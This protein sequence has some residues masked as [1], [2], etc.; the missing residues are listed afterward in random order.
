MKH[1]KLLA[2]SAILILG[3]N[4]AM[5]ADNSGQITSFDRRV[6]VANG[7][8]QQGTVKIDRNK[9]Q[10][11]VTWCSPTLL[12]M[13]VYDGVSSSYPTHYQKLDGGD[14]PLQVS[15]TVYTPSLPF[16]YFGKNYGTPTYVTSICS[17]ASIHTTL[18]SS[19][20]HS[21]KL[22]NDLGQA[23][24]ISGKKLAVV[25]VN[26][27]QGKAGYYESGSFNGPAYGLVGGVALL[28]A[29]VSSTVTAQCESNGFS[30]NIK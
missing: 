4:V 15:V 27:N 16:T 11:V 21:V 14:H 1:L 26:C 18:T 9:L 5:A 2:V 6:F 24:T 17:P 13:R 10:T 25:T 12:Q 8:H 20:T 7:P 22:Q 23:F 29:G 3:S 30:I 28:P 19:R